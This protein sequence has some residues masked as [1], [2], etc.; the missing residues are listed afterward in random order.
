M[1]DGLV[2]SLVA[3]VERPCRYLGALSWGP[4]SLGPNPGSA[5]VQRHERSDGP[6]PASISSSEKWGRIMGAAPRGAVSS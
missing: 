6:A 3:E 4:G 2:I 5:R 1:A